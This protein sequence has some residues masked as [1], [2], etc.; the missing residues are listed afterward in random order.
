MKLDGLF[1]R[2]F[3]FKPATLAYSSLFQ[4]LLVHTEMSLIFKQ[5]T[6]HVQKIVLAKSA[7]GVFFTLKI[8]IPQ[9]SRLRTK[10]E[11]LQNVI[12]S[13][14]IFHYLCSNMI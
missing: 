2:H 12:S 6:V 1:F 3:R 13:E 11:S 4:N 10:I 14:F 9:A 7:T 5:L 8:V